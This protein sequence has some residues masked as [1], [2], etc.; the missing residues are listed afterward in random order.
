[1]ENFFGGIA[2]LVVVGAVVICCF[3]NQILDFIHQL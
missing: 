3:G 2:L 1:M